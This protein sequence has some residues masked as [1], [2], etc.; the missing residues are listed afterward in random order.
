MLTAMIRK[1]TVLMLFRK[2]AVLVS[3]LTSASLL[4]AAP[5]TARACPNEGA[6]PPELT[7]DMARE[8]VICL[9]NE[10]RN[11]HGAGKLRSDPRLQRAAQSHSDAMNAG[12]FFDHNQPNGSSPLERIQNTGYISGAS[13]WGIAENI[14]WGSGG[15]ASPRMAVSRWMASGAHRR[16]MLSKRYRQVGVGVAIGSPAGSGSD[17]A[18]YTTDFGYRK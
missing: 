10:E 8:A 12:N 6:T 11:R 15:Q 2:G 16:S 18:I 7:A 4:L 9:I 5:A 13:S 17:A 3:V 1:G 14:R